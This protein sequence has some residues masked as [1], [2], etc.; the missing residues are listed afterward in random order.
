M[1]I[2]TDC[3]TQTTSDSDDMSLLLIPPREQQD[4]QSVKISQSMLLDNSERS[5]CLTIFYSFRAQ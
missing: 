5:H 4:T 1:I 3:D 2:N